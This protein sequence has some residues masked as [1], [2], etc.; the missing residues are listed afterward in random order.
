MQSLRTEIAGPQIGVDLWEVPAYGRCCLAEIRLQY[1]F[2]IVIY[3]KLCEK[4]MGPLSLTVVFLT[5]FW[6]TTSFSFPPLSPE[7]KNEIK[8]L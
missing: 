7:N 6:T 4:I 5:L 1:S 2:L 3:L 8:T